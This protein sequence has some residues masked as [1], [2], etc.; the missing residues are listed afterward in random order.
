MSQ[1][2]TWNK[3]SYKPRFA[4]LYILSISLLVGCKK[5]IEV[6]PPITGYVSKTVYENG[7]QASAAV[8]SVYIRMI[9]GSNGLSSGDESISL[10][11]A[12]SADELDAYH[13]AG[14]PQLEFYHNALRSNNRAVSN[15]WEQ[16]FELIY[17]C[18]AAIEGLNNSSSVSPSLKQQLVGEAKFMRA[19]LY[20]YATNLWGNTP[21]ILTTDYQK[22]RLFE[23]NSV[24]QIYE[25]IVTDLLDAQTLLS[26]EY[27][28]PDNKATGERVRPNKWAAKA[29]LARVYLYSKDWTNAEI[30]STSIIEKRSLFSLVPDLNQVFLNSSTE[31]IWQLQPVA[32]DRNTFEGDTYI[33]TAIPGVAQKVA[34]SPFLLDAFE[35]GDNRLANW[36]GTFNGFHYPYKYKIRGTGAPL[37]EFLMVLRL[38]EQYLIRA[39]ARA[40]L[41]NTAG[42]VTDLNMI[43]SRA[44]LNKISTMPVDNL[45]KSIIHERQ[46]ELFM[47]WAHRW[48][49]LKRT[50]SIDGTMANVMEHKGG[51]W[52]PNWELYPIPQTE[53]DQA[54]NLRPQN[55]GY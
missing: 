26:D 15:K 48:F 54:P 52:L 2:C 5:F 49:D 32:P 40:H 13:T 12:L 42:A 18:N 21:L 39:E 22:N 1:R 53:L 23:R 10:L 27:M 20:F 6:D 7:A 16:F 8:T 35:P 47:E 33:L 29:L 30:Q 3:Y 43:R 4:L 37:S 38:A 55:S 17:S 25:Q 11:G 46:I 51:S 34:I 41:G 31:A 44:G 24:K 14:S 9:W 28:T 45:L 50:G 36:V 19:F